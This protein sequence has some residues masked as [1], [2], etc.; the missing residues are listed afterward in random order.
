M[1]VGHVRERCKGHWYAVLSIRNP[2]DRRKVKWIKLKATG[3]RQAEAECAR[4]ITEI[5]SGGYCESDRVTVGQ[6]LERWLDHVRTQVSPRTHERY[7]EIVR[8]NL[9]P[10]LGAV[11][12]AKLQPTQI[13]HGLREIAHQRPPERRRRPFSAHRPPY[14]PHSQAGPRPGDCLAGAGTQPRQPSQAA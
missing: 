12:L 7:A 14:A 10:A 4:L 9:I 6:F 5:H 13:Q 2:N 11:Q 1:S 3:K 8:K